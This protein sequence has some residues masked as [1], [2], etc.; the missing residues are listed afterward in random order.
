LEEEQ[1]VWAIPPTLAT[2]KKLEGKSLMY[3]KVWLLEKKKKVNKI[4][5]E[6]CLM[7]FPIPILLC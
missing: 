2:T 5:T 1:G 4:L 6:I 7:K 3:N